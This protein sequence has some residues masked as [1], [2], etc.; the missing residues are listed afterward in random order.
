M[1]LGQS[2]E[3]R[4]HANPKARHSHPHQEKREEMK[5]VGHCTKAGRERDTHRWQG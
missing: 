3:I 1:D 5:S 4:N 2:E